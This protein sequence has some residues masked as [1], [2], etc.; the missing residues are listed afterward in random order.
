M[1]LNPAL[2]G[3]LTRLAEGQV[4]APRLSG[5]G[6]VAVWSEWNDGDW[7]LLRWQD[8]RAEAIGKGPAHDLDPSL[9]ED[10]Q[11]VVWT[12]LH[13]DGNSDVMQWRDGEVTTVAGSAANES[14]A[15]VSGDGRTV[16]WVHDDLTSPIGFDLYRCHD[17]QTAPVTQG[18]EVD[19]EPTLNR[20]GS[21]LYFRRRVDFDGGDLWMRDPGGQLKQV[22]SSRIQEFGATASAA[23][24]TLVWSQEERGDHNLYRF[25]TENTKIVPVADEAG[26]NERDASVSADGSRMAYT[27]GDQVMLWENGES[28]ALTTS[29]SNGWPQLSNDGRSV[30]FWSYDE[31]ERPGLYLFERH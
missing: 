29:G 6:R 5:D 24:N 15:R 23:G 27:R 9:S 30:A 11:V 25:T 3:R 1:Q 20:D 8:G 18:W 4:S 17:G 19:L 28:V 22:T 12:R 21:W 16:V 10:G 31:G 13:P 7:D 26:V 2:P 14:Q